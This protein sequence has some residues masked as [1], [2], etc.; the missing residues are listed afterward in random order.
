[1]GTPCVS[2]RTSVKEYHP[3]ELPIVPW[4]TGADSDLRSVACQAIGPLTP[5]VRTPR[6]AQP[7]MRIPSSTA[8]TKGKMQRF[9]PSSCRM[10]IY[11]VALYA[12]FGRVSRKY[13]RDGIL[14][15]KIPL[16]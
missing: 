16:F 4:G 14:S 11:F 15:R 5:S 1:M 6:D 12:D 3:V 2:L 9:M 8:I 13:L 7:T 10:G